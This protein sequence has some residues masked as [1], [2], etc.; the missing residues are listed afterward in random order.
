MKEFGIRKVLGASR[1]HIG[2]LLSKEISII[3]VVSIIVASVVGHFILSML[4]DVIFAYHIL[5]HWTH[6]I[7]PVVILFLIVITAVGYK[8]FETARANPVSQLRSE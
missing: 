5:L 8:I 7:W 3:L 6:F 2:K 1:S 4:L